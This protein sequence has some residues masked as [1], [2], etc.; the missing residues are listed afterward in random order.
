[1]RCNQFLPR[2]ATLAQ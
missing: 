2:D 1:M